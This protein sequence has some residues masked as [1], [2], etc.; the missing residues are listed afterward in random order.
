MPDTTSKRTIVIV[1]GGFAGAYMARA[2]EKHLSKDWEIVLF[3]EE[4]Y[5]TFTPLL[6][7][8]VGSSIG[9]QHVV[10]PVRQFV[11]RTLCRTAT[12]TRLQFDTR[13]VEYRQADG[14]LE[15][16]PYDHLVLACGMIVNTGIMPGLASHAFPLK[17]M[18]DA[19][20]LRNHVLSRLE[21]AEI[22]TN[23]ERRR[24][25]LNFAVIGGGFS[26]VEVAGEIYDL[27]FA[28]RKY[29]PSL[30]D[31]PPHVTV[32][33]GPKRLLPE[34]PE[35]LGDYTRRCMEERGLTIR[36][37]THAHAVTPE[38]VIL[39][40][41]SLVPAG[42]VVCTIGNAVSPLL[43]TSSLPLQHGRLTTASDMSVPGQ[44]N[45]WAMGDCA[46]VPNAQDG[47]M[48]PTLAQ[49]AIRQAVQLAANLRSA[50]AGK[51]TRPF[52]YH[53][54]GSFAAIG[55][56]RAVGQVFGFKFSGFLAWFMWRSIYLAKMPTLARK[57][58]VAFD[59]FWDMFFPRDIVQ[60]SFRKTRS[61]PRAHY[62]PGEYVYRQGDAAEEF[63]IIEKGKAGV[64]LQG[65]DKPLTILGAGKQFG[66]G[67]ILASST[68]PYSIKAEEPLDVLAM[69][70]DRLLD[71][72]DHLPWL[73]DDLNKHL[74]KES[75]SEQTAAASSATPA[76]DDIRT[77]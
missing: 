44:K 37:E 55:H 19:L 38:G 75:L 71:L 56:H 66:V 29:Y 51:P 70:R 68:E 54:L 7:E 13:T 6:A 57:I 40:D 11:R 12:V 74:V 26:G 42:T 36:L 52:T 77:T 47:K 28:C 23:A 73:R 46:L 4:N 62:E 69:G 9:P 27:L 48:S 41:G 10:R 53:I 2:L 43:A 58:Q 72:V 45:L 21:L 25:L 1:G 64:Y 61:I 31:T 16:Q 14:R 60:L 32:L 17:N 33:H 39:S 18:G 8:V 24:H 63:Y 20:A 35:S 3:S 22:E 50:I 5:L 49:F 15:T 65:N 67:P 34:L 59:W 30:K 76:V